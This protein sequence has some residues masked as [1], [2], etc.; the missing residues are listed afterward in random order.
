[1][2]L[3]MVELSRSLGRSAVSELIAAREQSELDRLILDRLL[4]R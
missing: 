2:L 3:T 1:M 4:G